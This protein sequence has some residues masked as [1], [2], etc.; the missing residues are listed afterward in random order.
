LKTYSVQAR[1]LLRL[2][3]T[4]TFSALSV[5]GSGA[6]KPSFLSWLLWWQG[7]LLLL[8]KKLFAPC[9]I[10]PLKE[11]PASAGGWLVMMD[12][13]A[14]DARDT[15]ETFNASNGADAR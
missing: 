4:C 2:Q 15:L 5:H 7:R 11:Q 1:L 3:P 10:L 8:Q 6:A 9:F 14:I 13:A 12:A